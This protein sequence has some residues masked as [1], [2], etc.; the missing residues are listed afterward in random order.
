MQLMWQV[1]QIVGRDHLF[2][3]SILLIK[4]WCYFESRTLGSYHGLISTY[5][6]ETLILYILHLFHNSL[7]GPLAVSIVHW[8]MHAMF[9]E[10]NIAVSAQMHPWASNCVFMLCRFCT[11]FWITSASL[12]GSII[13]LVYMGEFHNLISPIL[14]VRDSLWFCCLVAW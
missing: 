4:A 13:V 3:R 12:I 9:Y 14:S 10:F 11:N 1:D 6:L 7:S 8:C 2:K 5:A